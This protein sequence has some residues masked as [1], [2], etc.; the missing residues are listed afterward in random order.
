MSIKDALSDRWI[1]LDHQATG[2]PAVRRKAR[3]DLEDA[4]GTETSTR[5]DYAGRYP[6]E[7]LQ[8]AHD[9]C[10]DGGVVGTARFV[11]TP[12]ALLVANEGLAF[13]GDRIVSLVRQGSSEKAER[14]PHRRTIGY[15]GIGFSSVFEITDCPQVISAGDARFQFD[16]ER[17]RAHVHEVLRLKPKNVAARAFPFALEPA[18][19][20]AD[21]DEVTALLKAG[22]VTVIRLPLRRGVRAEDVAATVRQTLRPEALVFMPAVKAIDLRLLGAHTS[23]MR[24]GG[25]RVKRGEV[26][27]L[28]QDGSRAA[29]WLVS[30]GGVPVSAEEATRLTDPAW[31]DVRRA[32]VVVGLPW[33]RGVAMGPTSVPVHVYFPTEERTGRSVLV[34]ADFL[35]DSR[36][37]AVASKGP[38]GELNRR[39]AAA[40]ARQLGELAESQ[41]SRSSGQVCA[42]LAR[43]EGASAFGEILGQELLEA[44]R[45]R[46]LV[47]VLGRKTAVRVQQAHRTTALDTDCETQLL[48][49]VRRKTGLV[50][51]GLAYGRA[52]ALLDELGLQTLGAGALARR[53]AVPSTPRRHERALAT[54]EGWLSRLPWG[55]RYAAEHALGE[56]PILLDRQGRLWPADHVVLSIGDAPSLPPTLSKYEMRPLGDP[57]A[58]A[59]VERL[60]VDHLDADAALDVMLGALEEHAY[61]RSASEHA[62]VLRFMRA[63]WERAR[64]TLTEASDRLGVVRVPA[65]TA[66]G[67]ADGWA[68]ADSVYFGAQWHDA[69]ELLE[70]VYGPFGEREFLGE[71]P[72]ADAARRRSAAAFYTTL[73]VASRPRIVAVDIG[74]THYHQW[75]ATAGFRAALPCPDGHP[76][77]RQT[78]ATYTST[79]STSFS[80]ARRGTTVSPWRG[81]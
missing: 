39:M 12:H 29:S 28:D 59:F 75:Q 55:E 66:R 43:H 17:A 71:D 42:A 23:W 44:L 10:A 70:A 73:G 26:I 51:P 5:I 6:V 36:R 19:F 49:L 78:V 30:R 74:A 72:P 1:W 33:D 21:A 80:R 32:E 62:T 54:L 11:V 79:D 20:A 8:N 7:L 63:M 56:R 61:G 3:H 69:G 68:D 47:S 45:R 14:R 9:A 53:I 15:K 31:E 35:I 77:G 40:A 4:A 27:H 67:R 34:H 41:A 18:D 2:A 48:G 58:R 60:D 38:R 76:A 52:G 24:R 50:R 57:A 81:C 22:A 65:R 64:A 13:N 46:R 37:A 16:R 25:Q